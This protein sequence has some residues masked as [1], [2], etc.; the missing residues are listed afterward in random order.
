VE[1]VPRLGTALLVRLYGLQGLMHEVPLPQPGA[2]V[3]LRNV[4]ACTVSGQLQV[5]LLPTDRKFVTAERFIFIK[6]CRQWQEVL[7]LTYI[8]TQGLFRKSSKWSPWQPTQEALQILERREAQGTVQGADTR[9]FVTELQCCTGCTCCHTTE[10][11]G[12]N[13]RTSCS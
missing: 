8:L 11:S 9:L 6:D 7:I 12:S 13:R 3:K 4:A 1:D 10:P 5:C 2:W